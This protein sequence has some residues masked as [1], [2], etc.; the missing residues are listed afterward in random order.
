MNITYLSI[1]MG[2]LLALAPLGVL[3]RFVPLQLK[4]LAVALLRMLLQLGVVAVL[5]WL[6]WRYDIIWLSLLLVLLMATVATF[7]LLRRVKLKSE[8]L[9]LP[10]W[11]AML[12]TTIG[13]G[14][15]VLFGILRPQ[16][17][18][19]IRWILPI[20][21]VLLAH[22][23]ATGVVSLQTYFETLRNDSLTYYE[24]IGNGA[25]RLNA[26]APY[27][28]RALE[29]L[30]RPAAANLVVIGLLS[31]PVLLAGLMMGGLQP[32]DA[33]FIYAVLVVASIAASMVFLLLAV[34]LADRRA[35][36]RRGQL[37]DLQ[38]TQ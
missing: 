3:Y 27:I 32:V 31:L 20:A 17:V 29:S 16:S 15:F 7:M 4:T 34:W 9:L 11:A 38:R 2:L 24:R 23:L 26:L 19:S 10:V 22:Q 13:V 37:L 35:F 25:S 14:G 18:L 33:V 1:V 28:G 21:A 36:D 6:L 8:V 5:M 30:V 12:I